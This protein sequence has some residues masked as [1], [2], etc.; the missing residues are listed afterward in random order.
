MPEARKPIVAGNWKMHKTTGEAQALAQ[1]IRGGVT[2]PQ[3]PD[4]VLCPP[5]TALAVVGAAVAGSLVALGAQDL[6]WE[7]KGAFTGEVSAEML[8][9]AGCRYVIV[10]HSERRA[11]FGET[12]E[13][14]RRKSAAALAAGLCPIVCVGEKLEDRETGR[15]PD[16]VRD[17]FVGAVEGKSAD[18]VAR[19][20]MA[21][22]P[23]WAI[24]TGR[25]ATA[26][27]AQEM[28]AFLRGL[29]EEMYDLATAAQT[30]IQYGGSVKPDNIA[31]LM[32][33]PD[34]DGALVGGASLD[35]RLFL[36]LVS[37]PR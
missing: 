32:A 9:D 22:E 34:I 13:M 27:Q 17:H 11:Y 25:T 26:D 29:I 4:V 35:A 33:E 37:Y 30:R 23:V 28:H 20:V 3:G 12:N 6:H 36:D 10:G 18:E 2:D 7:S 21:Y 5:F 8:L 14:V 19:M 1:A 24:G 15:A 16:V 31:G